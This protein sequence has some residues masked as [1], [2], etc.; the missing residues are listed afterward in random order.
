ML[1]SVKVQLKM[2][3]SMLLVLDLFLLQVM[4][5]I[6]LKKEK[7]LKISGQLLE[8]KLNTV[9]SKTWE[10]LQVSSQDYSHAATVLVIS[11]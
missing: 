2:N 6:F 4:H 10:L 3:K 8:E 7:R 9:Q 11:I 5:S 1:G